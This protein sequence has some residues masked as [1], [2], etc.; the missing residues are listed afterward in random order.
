MSRFDSS[1]IVRLGS[2]LFWNNNLPFLHNKNKFELF[3][4]LNLNLVT[5]LLLFYFNF[6]FVTKQKFHTNFFIKPTK[7]KQI[8]LELLNFNYYYRTV[9]IYKAD[10]SNTFNIYIRRSIHLK[11]PLKVWF[12]YYGDKLNIFWYIIKHF[13]TSYHSKNKKSIL[14]QSNLR[15]KPLVDLL[16]IKS[17]LIKTFINFK[18]F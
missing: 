9:K 18:T 8:K 15:S 5:K 16:N 14:N 4:N 11:F 10:F 17:K 7:L 13:K 3:N 6:G 12:I 1:L 2:N